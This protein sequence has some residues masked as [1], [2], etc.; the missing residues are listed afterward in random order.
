MVIQPF[1]LLEAKAWA[2]QEHPGPAGLITGTDDEGRDAWGVVAGVTGLVPWHLAQLLHQLSSVTAEVEGGRTAFQLAV[3]AYSAA[4]A[5]GVRNNLDKFCHDNPERYAAI[6]DACGPSPRAR[7]ATP[8]LIDWR[9]FAVRDLATLTPVVANEIVRGEAWSLALETMCKS[10]DEKIRQQLLDLLGS[11]HHVPPSVGYLVEKAVLSALGRD[12]V[13]LSLLDRMGL[14]PPSQGSASMHLKVSHFSTEPVGL[15]FDRPVLLIPD[16][17]NYAHVDGV[18]VYRSSEGTHTVIG[19]QVTTTPANKHQ[20]SL[21]FLAGPWRKFVPAQGEGTR[22]QAALCWITPEEQLT[23]ANL[24]QFQ[25]YPRQGHIPL[26]EFVD[27]VGQTFLDRCGCVECLSFRC[28]RKLNAR[29]A[30]YG[31]S[32]I[33]CLILAFCSLRARIR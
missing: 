16:A 10:A 30:V 4:H 3:E 13:P 27:S 32:F 8:E 6:L 22:C 11:G 31:C 15:V 20:A 2:V 12:G 17:Y 18:I 33:T 28:L 26:T 7:H 14:K 23:G 9:Y 19:I 25:A 1:T 5:S 21:A 24:P 29:S